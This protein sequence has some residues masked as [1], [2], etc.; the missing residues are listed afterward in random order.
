MPISKIFEQKDTPPLKF[1]IF[2]DFWG[3]P[4]LKLKN[5]DGQNVL[6]YIV[7]VNRNWIHDFYII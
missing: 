5:F 1:L 4:P 3:P 7:G 6:M 2:S